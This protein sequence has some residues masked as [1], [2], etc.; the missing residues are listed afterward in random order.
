MVDQPFHYKGRALY[1][2]GVS[3]DSLA[4]K[5]GT[6]LYVYSAGKIRAQFERYRRAYAGQE[7]LVCFAMK[8]NSNL[9]VLSL[10]GRLGAGMDIVSG[11]E[12]FRVRKAGVPGNRIVFS[13]VGKRPDEIAAALEAGIL[14]FNVESAA[15]LDAI[16][17]VAKKLKKR[18]PISIRVNPNV[19]AD[20]HHHITTGKAENKFGVPYEEVF[21]LYQ[22]AKRLPWLAITGIQAHIGSQITDVRPF[23]ETVEKL[24]KLMDRLAAAGIAPRILDIGGGLGVRYNAEKAPDPA[25]QAK[26]ILP[27][28]RGRGLKLLFEPG[29]FMVAE[30]GALITKV[31]YRK[32]TAHKNFVI[33]DAAM[34]DLARP[35]LYD[36]FHPIWP[37]RKN[38][39][40]PLTADIV[41]PVCES[42]DY[43]AKGRSVPRPHPGDHLAVL[44]AGAYGFSMSSQYN[45]RP[46]A[47]EALV[48]GRR[49]WV[50]RKRETLDDLVRGESVPAAF[51][52]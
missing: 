38:G 5:L 47:C 1:A 45:A 52:R 24:L 44:M 33:V 49:W 30:S 43:L 48:D 21:G 13:G 10:L 18:A 42:G 14:M 36:A 35:A 32:E 39:G 25:D 9:A 28:L 51:R 6:P 26:L 4:R 29:R 27:L 2:E 37:V 40:K 7:H 50:V 41:G 3:L 16:H 11:G 17:A 34:N 46:R 19:A 23:R 31:L 12:L 8:S 20:T 15:E 22:K